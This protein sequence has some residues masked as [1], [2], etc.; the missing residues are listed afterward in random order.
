MNSETFSEKSFTKRDSEKMAKSDRV[1]SVKVL[2]LIGSGKK[3]LDLGAVGSLVGDITRLIKD[4]GNEVWAAD[5]SD[6]FA[7]DFMKAGITFTKTDLE[8]TFPYVDGMFDIVFA[9][10]II[11]H[12]ADTDNFI[13][14]IK[15]VLK[16]DGSLILTTPNVVSFGRRVNVLL[17]QNAFFE[18]SFTYPE[19]PAGH[20]RFFTFGLLRD[21]LA[22]HGLRV[23]YRS[24]DV[25]SFPGNIASSFLARVFPMFGRSII[26]KAVH[27]E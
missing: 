8:K 1:R 21:F 4:Q 23:T 5:A 25:V 11:E 6:A 19:H 7:E 16:K 13:S 26:V 18:A 17:G 2:E 14:E 24:S 3:V 10:E 20:L 12:L 27:V 22:L 9:G 15:R